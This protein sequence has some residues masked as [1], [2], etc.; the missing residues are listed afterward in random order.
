MDFFASVMKH[1]TP[2]AGLSVETGVEVHATGDVA[3]KAAGGCVS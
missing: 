3:D 2:L 1:A